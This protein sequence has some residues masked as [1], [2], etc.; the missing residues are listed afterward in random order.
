MTPWGWANFYPRAFIL[1]N[2]VD[3]YK[4]MFHA[5]YLNSSYLGSLKEDFLIFY[6]IQIRKIYDP[7]G[8]A[9]FEFR[10]FI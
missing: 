2:L 8:R 4:K 6:Y 3:T 1:T 10:A 7:R 5:L 9:N